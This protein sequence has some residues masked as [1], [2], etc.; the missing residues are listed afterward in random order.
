MIEKLRFSRKALQNGL[1]VTGLVALTLAVVVV[2]AVGPQGPR[3]FI[4]R[5][6]LS[7]DENA[8]QP[9]LRTGERLWAGALRAEAEGAD[10]LAD[11]LELQAARAFERAAVSAPGPRE[12]ML[13]NDRAADAYL[14]LGRRQ[15]ERGRGPGLRGRHAGALGAAERA[16]VCLVGLA[17]TRRRGQINA[18][19]VELEQVLERPLSGSCPR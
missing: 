14:A 1:A 13:A 12:E 5:V 4:D 7:M 15:L 3:D 16:A 6:A 9:N 18:F 11:A 19:V 17:P 10:S 2:Y 8:Y